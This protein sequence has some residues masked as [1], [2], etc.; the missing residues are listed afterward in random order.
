M[1]SLRRTLFTVVSLMVLTIPASVA[2]QGGRG[3]GGGHGGGG[4]DAGSLFGDLVHIKRD[5]TTGQPIL[6]KRMIEY[7]GDVVDWGYCPIPVDVYGVEVPLLDESCEVDP[8]FADRLIEVDYFNRLSG[9]RAGEVTLRMH[10]DEVIVKIQESEAVDRDPAG[11]LRMGTGCLPDGG[12]AEWTVVD[13]PFENLA[14]YHRLMKYGHV[15]TNPAEVDTSAHGDPALGTVYHPALRS[16]DWPKFRSAV[17]GMLPRGSVGLCFSGDT[18][19]AACA[20]PLQLTVEDFQNAASFLGGAAGKHEKMT[21]E[22]VQYL[23]RILFITKDTRTEEFTDGTLAT[24]NTVPALIRDEDGS[25][26]PAP[27]GLPAPADERFVDFSAASYLRESVFNTPAAV[28]VPTSTPGVWQENDAVSLLPFLRFINGPS[29]AATGM[30]AFVRNSSDALRAVEFVHEYEIP[31]DISASGAA[32]TMVVVP[33]AAGVSASNQAVTLFATVTDELPVNGGV[34][35][36]MV[37]NSSGTVVGASAVSGTV[38]NGLAAASYTVPGSTAVQVLILKAAYSGAPGFAPT[39]ATSTLT[40]TAAPPEPC[41]TSISPT[42]APADPAGATM[43]LMITTASACYWSAVSSATWIVPA[44][45]IGTG[46]TT[47]TYVVEANA[48][49]AA[50]TGTLTVG[51][52]VLTIT[53]ETA[54]PDPSTGSTWGDFYVPLDGRADAALFDPITRMWTFKG[55]STGSIATFGPFGDTATHQEVM[56]PA[57]Y[58]GDGVTDCAAYRPATGV[59]TVAPSCLSTG[60]YSVTLG[61]TATDV[62][63]PADFTGDGRTDFAVYRRATTTWYVL[64]STGGA[65]SLAGSPMPGAT[66]V[67]C[68]TSQPAPDWVCVNGGWVPPDHPLANPDIPPPTPS[69]TIVVEWGWSWTEVIP[70]PADYDGDG[71]ADFAYYAPFNA[72]WWVLSSRTGAVMAMDWG[73][74]GAIVIPV[75]ADYDGDGRVDMGY[76]HPATA[77]WYILRTSGGAQLATFGTSSMVPVPADYD[78]DRKID[79]ALYDGAAKAF[80]V[81]YSGTGTAVTIDVPAVNTGALPVLQKPR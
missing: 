24:L 30:T 56:V 41:V 25:I 52:H 47:L 59:W 66:T 62:P 11:R 4:G 27:E 40:V 22:V 43:S 48:T 15:Q 80:R 35:T 6:Q 69:E 26:S 13:A 31:A 19:L 55:S 78:G 76:F 49:G 72:S 65:P 28:L 44:A 36:F 63:V 32:T 50:R 73:M 42:T 54:S 70:V 29:V 39:Y 58:T 37:E 20:E 2:A 33:A 23:N 14:F 81:L 17:A 21:V 74:P 60:Q 68:T 67:P 46:T 7:P 38:A 12:C 75:P 77:G 51:A 5:P 18:F 10:F 45:T 34:V 53:Q 9:A 8:A 3:G 71:T 64:P 61:G 57:D 79:I 16:V 1:P